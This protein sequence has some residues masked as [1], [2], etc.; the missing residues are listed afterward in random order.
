MSQFKGKVGLVVWWAMEFLALVGALLSVTPLVLTL[1]TG[2]VHVGVAPK[3][4]NA[5]VDGDAVVLAYHLLTFA[6]GAGVLA[7]AA[8]SLVRRSLAAMGSLLEMLIRW[9]RAR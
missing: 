6:V 1:A 8:G 9:L 2:Q 5:E 4:G 3:T 7:L